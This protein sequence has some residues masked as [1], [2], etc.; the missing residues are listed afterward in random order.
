[1]G[2]GLSKDK[3][4]EMVKKS[5]EDKGIT[6]EAKFTVL[7]KKSDYVHEDQG[8]FYLPSNTDITT[9]RYV[10]REVDENK[11]PYYQ[12]YADPSLQTTIAG[13]TYQ[14]YLTTHNGNKAIVWWAKRTSTTTDINKHTAV[15]TVIHDL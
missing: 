12:L 8:K 9:G 3:V 10:R 14:N 13:K 5:L 7:A 11:T 15:T 6:K 1:M 2:Q 4:D